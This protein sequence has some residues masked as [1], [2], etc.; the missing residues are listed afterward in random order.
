MTFRDGILGIAN[1]VRGIPQSMGLRPTTVTIRTRTWSGGEKGEGTYTDEDTVI[2][3]TPRLRELSMQ[4]VNGSAGGY[5]RGDIKVG[6]ITPPNAAGGYSR[7]ELE[8]PA[9]ENGIES[10]FVLTG[11]NAG[12]YKS[13]SSFAAKGNVSFFIILRRRNTRGT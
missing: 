13:V 10:F 4:E 2:V 7:A 3:P 6:P 9:E 5:E 1:A 8:R 11:E 12:E